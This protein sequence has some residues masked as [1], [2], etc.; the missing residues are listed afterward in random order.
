MVWKARG[1]CGVADRAGVGMY[2]KERGR[3]REAVGTNLRL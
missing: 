3:K 1:E 2:G